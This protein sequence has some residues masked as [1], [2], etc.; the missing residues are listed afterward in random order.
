MKRHVA[1]LGAVALCSAV[2]P[3]C[4]D[5]V[6]DFNRSDG[7]ISVD[8]LGVNSTGPQE[9]SY[10]ER[11]SNSGP[12]LTNVAKIANGQLGLFG[13]GGGLGTTVFNQSSNPGLVTVAGYNNAY[14]VVTATVAFD[15]GTYSTQAATIASAGSL[16]ANRIGY[17]LAARRRT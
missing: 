11:G 10:T 2:R 9:F 1:I 3:V 16:M 17:I 7:T 13:T 14:P 4:A 6:D 15:E 12:D 5:L 8:S